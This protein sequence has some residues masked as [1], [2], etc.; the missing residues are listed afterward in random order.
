MIVTTESG[1]VYH[2]GLL[3]KTWSRLSATEN[4]GPLR[5][6]GG[7]FEDIEPIE[8]GKPVTMFCP[9]INPPYKRLIQTSLVTKIEEDR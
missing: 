4:S 3:S 7:E 6:Q 2:I 9:S 8:I 5:S 1:S